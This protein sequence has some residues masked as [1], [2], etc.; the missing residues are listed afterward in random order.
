MVLR[1]Q[2]KKISSLLTLCSIAFALCSATAYAGTTTSSNTPRNASWTRQT[3]GRTVTLEISPQPVR[4]MADL[5]FTVTITPGAAIPSTLL[6]D[7][8]MPEMQ[9]GKNQVVLIRKSVFTWE[10][11]GVIVRCMSGRKLWQATILST[12]LGN[13]A[14]YFETRD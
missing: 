4:H 6:L 14:F 12:E 3:A 2:V 9:M 8:A 5:T 1:R 10:G 7:L 13:P 11:K